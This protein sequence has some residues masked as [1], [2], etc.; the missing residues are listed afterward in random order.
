MTRKSDIYDLSKE[1]IIT[2]VYQYDY[3]ESDESGMHIVPVS[4]RHVINIHINFKTGVPQIG[5][6]MKPSVVLPGSTIGLKIPTVTPGAFEVTNS[7]WEIFSNI[8]DA[9]N[10]INGQ[11]YYN[12]LT[13]LYWYQN[14]Y[15]VA[16]Y[17]QTYLG[18]TY[19]NHVPFTVANYHDLRQ[20]MEDKSNHYF[21]DHEDAFKERDPKIYINA[22]KADE[23]EA[24]GAAGPKNRLD[25]LKDLF[26][27]SV[28]S[29]SATEG[30]VTEEGNL[31]GHALLDERVKGC[32]NLDI[33]MRT[34]VDHPE[35]WTSIANEEGQ[36]FEGTFHGDGYYISGLNN[37]LFGNLCGSVYNLGVMGSFTTA[38]VALKG[39]GYAE[40]CWVMNTQG[41][42]AEPTTMASGQNPII[43]E[44]TR[45]EGTQIVNCYYPTTN[46][47]NGTTQRGT[48]TQRPLRAF[49][50]GE[51]AY[52]L[53]GFYLNK[54]YNDGIN[55]A[56]G[57]EYQYWKPGS[58]ELQTGHYDSHP[59]YCSSGYNGLKYVEDRYGN[60]DFIY[61]G[62][63]IPE[64]TNI[65]LKEGTTDQYYPI[66]PD[67]YIFFGQALTYGWD[68]VNLRA[69]QDVPSH[70]NQS[71]E[72]LQTGSQSNRVYR[73]PAYFRS[74]EMG[75]AHFNPYA[76]FAQSK[77]G[78]AN[79]LAYKN[80]TA[81]D[82]TGGNGDW[83]GGYELGLNGNKFYAPLLDDDGLTGF[84]NADLTQ[85]LL[86]YTGTAAPAK[87]QTDATVNTALPDPTYSED[88]TYRAVDM[89]FTSSIRGHQVTWNGSSYTTTKDH[90]LVDKNDFNAPIQYTM[91]SGKRMW[92]QRNPDLFVDRT[93]GWE[94]ISI[95]F[96]AELVTTNQKG[97]ITHFYAGSQES[98][99][100]TRTK[101]GHEYWL[102]E[103]TGIGPKTD[104]PTVTVANMT[105]PATGGSI[106]SAL[107][108]KTVTNTFL[109]DYYYYERYEPYH[110]DENNDE[111]QTYYADEREYQNYAYLACGTPYI[112][113]FPGTTYYEFDLSGNWTTTTT[114]DPDPDPSG[115]SKQTITFASEP[116]IKI[117]V[118]DD[119]IGRMAVSKDGYTFKP[120]YLNYD[121]AEEDNFVLATDGSAYNKVTDETTAA[122]KK[123]TAFRPYFI[124]ASGGN[125]KET[126]SIVFSN[127]QSSLR[128]ESKDN[129]DQ[130]D[131]SGEGLL[132]S[133]K[134]KRIYVTSAYNREVQ[135]TIVNTAGAV[136]NSFS[137][138]PGETMETNVSSGVY[139]VN[140]IKIAVK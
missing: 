53:N 9:D 96:T 7:G 24:A 55:Q 137:L 27:L 51:V 79:V 17:T 5:E 105:Y 98:K 120:T 44:P 21:I 20:V 80:M 64:G 93:K 117:D 88:V 99:N 100:G 34:N 12:N 140:K 77:K 82:F 115:L 123:I 42:E 113:G 41:T 91:G 85:N 16:Y 84:V 61:A 87:A 28:F 127:E 52:D 112:I 49:Y 22:P 32:A 76:I 31:K 90:L 114:A 4:E 71:G 6:L 60:V 40:N 103:F 124:P 13:P 26:D 95:P 48:A 30:V 102:R 134:S 108:K 25:I 129:P 11:P 54:R 75:V 3:Q 118:S 39:S 35:A 128:G 57:L 38:G 18:K 92:Y 70:I 37:S 126:R 1:R 45:S 104:D 15:R 110:Q 130:G 86:A 59:E 97:E 33:I 14:D 69:H 89:A 67:D 81:I 83:A 63:T 50:N 73:A 47:F 111:Y 138:Q 136:V 56:S 116:G 74:K 68:D 121:E 78:D 131:A 125:V 101:I 46:N 2:V 66:W 65:R 36:C 29:G 132:V 8:N 107:A 106:S 94:G 72:R 43:G 10:H 119:E 139:L 23:I 19:S 133:A 109:W 135:V 58:D 62:G 122:N